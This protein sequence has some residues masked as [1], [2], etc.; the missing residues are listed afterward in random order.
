MKTASVANH[1]RSLRLASTIT[2]EP[3][4]QLERRLELSTINITV[5]SAIPGATDVLESVVG[6]HRRLPGNIA[7][8]P[9]SL[10][11]HTI[12]SIIDT[13]TAIDPDRPIEIRRPADGDVVVAIAATAPNGT[14]RAIP[15]QHG[16]R[17]A[18]SGDLRQTRAP[19]GL[20]I[21]S[22]AA[23]IAGELFKD[24]ARLRGVRGRRQQQWSF[25]PVTLSDDPDCGPSLPERWRLDGMLI[26]HGALGTATAKILSTLPVEGELD[27]VDPERFE[28]ENLG[29][30]ALGGA[31]EAI[32]RPYKTGLS[33]AVLRRFATREHHLYAGEIPGL[34]DRGALQWPRNVLVGLDSA[35]ARRDAQR[36]WPDV[37]IDGGTGDTM[38]S[39]H[40]AHGA[41]QPCMA[42]FFPNTTVPRRPVAA[43][44][45]DL[46]TLPRE[47]LVHGDH[48]LDEQD[49]L[50]AA[51]D[52][53]EI[54]RGYIGGP[55]CSLASAFGLTDLPEEGYQPAVP[56]VAMASAALV[57]G[58]LVAITTGTEPAENFVQYDT[59][60]GP[61]RRT[62]ERRRGRPSC[63]CERHHAIVERVRAARAR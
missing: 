24:A 38:V 18:R 56:F 28:P 31:R 25:C 30:Y 45:P 7:V 40:V 33:A 21:H 49:L 52:R 5:D 23:A 53:R 11:A 16:A 61:D 8:D 44:L 39:L 15:D 58:R 2:D 41:G 29:T 62:A 48:I 20:G 55:V 3:T 1:S 19:S 9:A 47:L 12:G 4:S 42:C 57:V 17:L 32:E 6:L 51:V 37:L 63:D 59:L 13:A 10:D 43:D 60:V 14:L 26:G 22:T 35:Q 27:L 50:L 54:L 34:I 46:T 36:V